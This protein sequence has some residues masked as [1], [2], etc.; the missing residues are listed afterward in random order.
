MTFGQ[1]K[2]NVE[3]K[4]MNSYRNEKE[5]KKNILEFKKNI[6]QKKS[7]SKLYN[8]Y[9]Q[10]STPQGMNES[11]AKEYLDEGLELITKLIYEVKSVKTNR[12]LSENN[13]RDIDN[14]IYSSNIDLIERIN[15]KNRIIQILTSEKKSISE[16]VN[17]PLSSMVNI[18]NQTI[19]NYLSNLNENEK[20]EVLTLLSSDSKVLEENFNSLKKTTIS[21]LN[22]LLLSENDTETKT[23]ISETI[24][25][26][27]NDKCD[28]LSYIKLKSLSE[29][30]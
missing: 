20:E 19:K 9:D 28:H 22:S 13:Y 12:I 5:F 15:S 29:T 24:D 1:I 4:L 30:L 23:K 6:L 10:L 27:E 21:K 26:L 8:L 7:L 17:L 2:T 14:L 16:N 25:K 3:N 11:L 18:A